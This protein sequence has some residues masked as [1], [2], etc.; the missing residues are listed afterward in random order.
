[1]SGG[2][3]SIALAV[4]LHHLHTGGLG[5][6]ILGHFDHRL[7]PESGLLAR[8]RV[9][10]LAR[11]LN[12]EFITGCAPDHPS[13]PLSEEFLRD[14]RYQFFLEGLQRT[15]ARYLALAHTWNDQVE[16]ILQR[17]LRGSGLRGLRGM[18]AFRTFGDEWVI[19]RPLL[20]ATRELLREMLQEQQQ[21]YCEDPTNKDV[22]WTRNWIRHELLPG[23]QGRFP[24]APA[25]LVRLSSQA[26]EAASALQIWATELLKEAVEFH[27]REV[28]ITLSPL[29]GRPEIVVRELLYLIWELRQWP[30]KDMSFGHWSKMAQCLAAKKPE[31]LTLPG[32]LHLII[33]AEHAS[34]TGPKH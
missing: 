24:H 32:D 23:M 14:Q 16:T 21:G 34:V 1:V 19:A 26:D 20:T 2:S 10:D 28:V 18:P 30:L 8:Q 11:T 13:Q 7:R 9:A 29:D 33:E 27:Q 12:A 22:R 5:R 25:A 31:T 15:G 6:L 3:D 17:I 4:A